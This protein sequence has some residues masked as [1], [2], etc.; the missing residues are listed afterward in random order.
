MDVPKERDS[1]QEKAD[2]LIRDIPVGINWSGDEVPPVPVEVLDAMPKRRVL[3]YKKT[4]RIE[5]AM[6]DD[7]V[8]EY[9]K[10]A[11]YGTIESFIDALDL[12]VDFHHRY[13][14]DFDDKVVV[15]V[16]NSQVEERDPGFF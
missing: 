3:T 4:Y 11:N 6:T 7:E 8:I 16:H 12:L 10:L 15:E 2:A 9:A 13:G 14:T 5:T 1:M